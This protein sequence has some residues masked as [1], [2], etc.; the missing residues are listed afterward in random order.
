MRILKIPAKDHSWS[1][2][3]SGTPG[4]DNPTPGWPSTTTAAVYFNESITGR[5]KTN[6]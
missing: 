3:P 4:G 6:S 1:L 5:R 2:A